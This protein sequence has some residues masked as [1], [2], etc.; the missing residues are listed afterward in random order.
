MTE[1]NY[2]ENYRE[3]LKYHGNAPNPRLVEFY[4]KA[5]LRQT[6]G[7]WI[8]KKQELKSMIDYAR[9]RAGI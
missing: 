5:I 1:P 9:L 7:N 8:T 6:G 3:Y 2:E 4:E